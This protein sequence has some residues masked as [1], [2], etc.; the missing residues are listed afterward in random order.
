MNNLTVTGKNADLKKFLKAVHSKT[1]D[2]VLDFEQ[3]IPM[4]QDLGEE[5]APPKNKHK[6]RANKIQYGAND[7]YDWSNKNWG[8]KW[9]ADCK[10][11]E[12]NGE[13]C[14][15]SFDTAW[16]PPCPIIKKLSEMF[17]TLYF[18]MVFFGHIQH[19]ERLS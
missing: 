10:E 12:L 18:R 15:M 14:R 8:T 6:A 11:A 7:W 5:Q 19:W 2:N 1:D 9:N 3:I 16:S 4:P 17:P 13:M